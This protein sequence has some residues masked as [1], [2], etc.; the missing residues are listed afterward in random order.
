MRFVR[1]CRVRQAFTLVELLVVIAIIG[2][3]VGLLLPAVQKIRE[4]AARMSCS[5]NLRQIILATHNCHDTYD[6]FPPLIGPYPTPTANG[7][8]PN[9]GQ[10]G[11][12]TPLVFL[13]EFI[14]QGNLWKQMLNYSGGA[15]PLG[16]ADPNNSYSVPDKTYTCPSDPSFS[17]E[18][19]VPQNPGG[20]P[21]AAGSSYAANALVFD[22]C[23]YNPGNGTTPPSATIT[24]AANLGL[25]NDG[26][27]LPP[28]NYTRFASITDGLSSTVFFTEKLAFCM[29]APQGPAELLANGGACNGP[30]GDFFCGGSNWGDPLLDFFAPTYNDLPNGTITPA[31]TIQVRPNFQVNCDPIRP[32]AAHTAII[33][34]AMGDG[35]VRPISA[36]ISPM[37]WFLANV[38]NDG[39]VL[40]SDW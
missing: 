13:L 36:A 19:G 22:R 32:S 4:S 37:T 33:N 9:I 6:Q 8:N 28:F 38:P 35:S 3:L 29:T 12:G 27:P 14:E 10:Q 7:Y 18:L 15:G 11:V 34:A 30:G 1:A 17:P 5:N 26:T 25:Q 20:P 21:F 24:N 40:P 23:I 31:F 2:I 39:Q 16:W